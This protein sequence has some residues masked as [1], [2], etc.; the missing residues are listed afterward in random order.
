MK[1]RRMFFLG[2]HPFLE[3]ASERALTNRSPVAALSKITEG[4]KPTRS[5]GIYIYIYI[6][7]LSIDRMGKF[8]SENPRKRNLDIDLP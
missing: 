5:I 6:T 4:R 3:I 2:K 7:D 8:A 1:T